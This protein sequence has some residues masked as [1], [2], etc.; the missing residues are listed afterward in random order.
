MLTSIALCTAWTTARGLPT[1]WRLIG[2][3]AT[4]H[5]Q[6][7]ESVFVD[8]DGKYVYNY[9]VGER[10]TIKTGGAWVGA[11]G[12]RRTP[13]GDRF[14]V[15]FISKHSHAAQDLGD[16]VARKLKADVIPVDADVV[17]AKGDLLVLLAHRFDTPSAATIKAVALVATVNGPEVQAAN[18]EQIRAVPRSSAT[19][20]HWTKNGRQFDFFDRC[21][22]LRY[23]MPHEPM[24]LADKELPSPL[25]E[26]DHFGGFWNNVD[27]PR[28]RAYTVI[29]R[30]LVEINFGGARTSL[31]GISTLPV[32]LLKFRHIFVGRL[33]DGSFLISV[34]SE[35]QPT[36]PA[37]VNGF[38]RSFV[39][40]SA[41]K[42]WRE[43]DGM[44]VLGASTDG[45]FVCFENGA[46]W[47]RMQVAEVPGHGN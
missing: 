20:Q 39:L 30:N 31:R 13:Q 43:F 47:N 5:R 34:E 26:D 46:P 11:I 28:N 18:D 41:R 14:R 17:Y 3:A 24:A 38:Y 4:V 27:W 40:D 23:I 44:R 42:R 8:L 29:G 2:T 9:S 1:N 37:K 25:K 45:R 36:S 12:V 33:R 32:D 35:K 7:P 19:W 16:S 21:L 22:A 6:I 15:A 10:W